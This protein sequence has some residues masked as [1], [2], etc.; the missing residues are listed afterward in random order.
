MDKHEVDLAKWERLER[1][2][3]IAAFLLAAISLHALHASDAVVGGA[4]GAASALV[5]P[6][7]AASRPRAVALAGAGAILGALMGGW[8][9]LAA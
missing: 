3:T 1:F 8:A 9:P 6:G 4:I 5:L 2:G 7:G